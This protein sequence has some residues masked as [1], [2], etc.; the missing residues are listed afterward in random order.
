M[1]VNFF[2]EVTIG[3]FEWCCVVLRAMSFISMML[4]MFLG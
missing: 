2:R 3:D 4:G 1:E